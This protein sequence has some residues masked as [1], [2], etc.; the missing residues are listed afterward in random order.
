M[1][2]LLII[3]LAVLIICMGM[4]CISTDSDGN[5]VVSV[6]D[7]PLIEIKEA[8]MV[9]EDAVI[10]AWKNTDNSSYISFAGDGTYLLLTAG[11]FSY[12]EWEIK[13][14]L[15]IIMYMEVWEETYYGGKGAYLGVNA[16]SYGTID[17]NTLKCSAIHETVGFPYGT[18]VPY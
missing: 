8:Q 2:K 3:S 7:T 6:G 17:N 5:T 14:N 1:K 13:N 10:G 18:Y 9:T 12:G 16:V 4:G 11:G 15:T